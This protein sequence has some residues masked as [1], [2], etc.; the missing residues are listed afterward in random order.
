[1]SVPQDSRS[2]EQVREDSLDL[3]APETTKVMRWPMAV[4]AM[5]ESS[6]PKPAGQLENVARIEM[7]PTRTVAVLG[8]GDA[9]TEPIVR[10]YAAVRRKFL[11]R[12]GLE[13]MTVEPGS[14]E[15]F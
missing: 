15:E 8:F 6:P 3:K 5:K 1:M 13:P 10:G 2:M 12:D 7:V 9:T 4:P 11:K 14:D